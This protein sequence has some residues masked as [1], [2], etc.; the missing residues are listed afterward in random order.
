MLKGSAYP[1]PPGFREAVGRRPTPSSGPLE[2][3]H[4]LL[5]L[6]RVDPTC[7]PHE[8]G[9]DELPRDIAT[10]WNLP[11]AHT[12]A[13]ASLPASVFGRLTGPTASTY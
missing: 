10:D 6:Y 12:V 11:V 3:L 13:R 1:L 8:V 7:V 2:P 4:A 5:L 9:F